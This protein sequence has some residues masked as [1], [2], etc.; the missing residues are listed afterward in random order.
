ME[1][2]APDE[3]EVDKE[4][5]EVENACPLTIVNPFSTLKD[6]PSENE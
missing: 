4:R 5:R 1:T 3:K 6:T 2:S